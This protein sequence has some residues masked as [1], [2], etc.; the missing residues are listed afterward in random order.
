MLKKEI[1]QSSFIILFSLGDW[2]HWDKKVQE[3]VYPTDSIPEYAS[4][5]V[6]NVDNVRT[7][8]LIDAIAKQHKVSRIF[9]V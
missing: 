1:S 9:L 6:P 4:I 3:Y 2:D 8:F 7:Q 5:L